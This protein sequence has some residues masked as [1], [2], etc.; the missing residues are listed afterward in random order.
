LS[1]RSKGGLGVRVK[2]LGFL[3]GIL[4]KFKNEK[5][6]AAVEFALLLPALTL[7]I[8]G[9]LM[10]GLIFHSYLEITHAA[11]E[12]VRWAA[13]RASETEVEEKARAAAPGIDWDNKVTFS[14]TIN[15]NPIP[16]GGAGVEQQG[17]PA[18]V[19]IIYD[20]TDIKGMFGTFGNVLPGNIAGG[21]IQRVE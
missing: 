7:I 21:A 10:L 11:R 3:I 15:G 16:A 18:T 17:Q 1:L 5:G 19:N 9:V 2:E 14:A 4:Q 20:I 8:I 6:A 12:G 13:L